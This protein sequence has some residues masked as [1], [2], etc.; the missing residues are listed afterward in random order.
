MLLYNH[1]RHE[2]SFNNNILNYAYLAQIIRK[3]L[4]NKY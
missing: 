3:I 1:I 4:V 2:N